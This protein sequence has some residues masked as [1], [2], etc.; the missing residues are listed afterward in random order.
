MTEDDAMMIHDRLIEII[1]RCDDS[2]TNKEFNFETSMR[3][4]HQLCDII[5]FLISPSLPANINQYKFQK[6]NK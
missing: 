5:M 6:E 1:K 3:D 2:V 4:M